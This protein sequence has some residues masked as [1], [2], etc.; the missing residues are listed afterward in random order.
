[1]GLFEPWQAVANQFWHEPNLI[2][3]FKK[4]HRE[5]TVFLLSQPVREVGTVL[6]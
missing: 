1:M 2:P 5:G 3:V 4:L 6:E